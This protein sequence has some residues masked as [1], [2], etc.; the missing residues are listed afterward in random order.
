[1][2]T[3]EAP[4]LTAAVWTAV[5]RSEIESL[6]ASSRMMLACGA[7]ACA[8]STSSDSS[9][10]QPDVPES[11]GSAAPPVWFSTVSVGPPGTLNCC[12]PNWVLNAAASLTIL[13]SL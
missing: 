1:M 9:T 10:D 2:E 3:T 5:I 7:M 13:G 6:L 11:A 4:Q 8:H 12:K